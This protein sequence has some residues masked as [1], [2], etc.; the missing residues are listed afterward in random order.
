MHE[1][2]Q[3]EGQRRGLARRDVPG[4]AAHLHGDVLVHGEHAAAHQVH[5]AARGLG[6]VHALVVRVGQQVVDGGHGGG[7]LGGLG[8]G[9]AHLVVVAAPRLH[10]QERGDGLQVVL[11]AVVDLADGRLFDAQ[12]ALAAAGLGEV[13][14]Q[15]EQAGAEGD[16]P[17]AERAVADLEL[18]GEGAAAAEER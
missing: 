12:L 8:E 3:G 10:A 4:A 16:G 17:V 11:H 1:L 18:A 14:H 13:L 9:A 7:A 6:E 5:D 2:G 15:H